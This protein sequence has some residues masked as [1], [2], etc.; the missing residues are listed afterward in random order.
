M[1]KEEGAD[2]IKLLELTKIY[3]ETSEYLRNRKKEETLKEKKSIQ[4]FNTCKHS[5]KI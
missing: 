5:E 4:Q 2:N 1:D 3:E